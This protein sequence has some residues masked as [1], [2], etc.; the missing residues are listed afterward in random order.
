LSFNLISIFEIS[1]KI[2]I[3]FDEI[4]FG[5]GKFSDLALMAQ[6]TLVNSIF[7]IKFGFALFLT[8]LALDPL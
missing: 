7:M 3:K 6:G 4:P 1:Q 8:F 5:L 2:S